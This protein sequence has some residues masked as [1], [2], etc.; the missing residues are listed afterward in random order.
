VHAGHRFVHEPTDGKYKKTTRISSE[1]LDRL[2]FLNFLIICVY[3]FN[4]IY[5]DMGPPDDTYRSDIILKLMST[6]DSILVAHVHWQGVDLLLLI[7][8]FNIKLHHVHHLPYE[9]G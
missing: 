6:E 2:F 5:P 7:L 1:K 9:G 3:I 8:I 4:T